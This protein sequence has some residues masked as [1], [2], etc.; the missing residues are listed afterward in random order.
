MFFSVSTSAA[1]G[2]ARRSREEETSRFELLFD[3]D[4]RSVGA[5]PL[6]DFPGAQTSVL[7]ARVTPCEP[8]QLNLQEQVILIK[9][10]ENHK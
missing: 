4:C 7:L 6:C 3:D 2:A 1:R 8:A 10:A 5:P 9:Q